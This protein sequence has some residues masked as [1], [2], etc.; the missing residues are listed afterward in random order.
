MTVALLSDIIISVYMTLIMR[1]LKIVKKYH[2]GC[3]PGG[4][5]HTIRYI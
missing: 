2:H 3:F 1:I 5:Y 4:A